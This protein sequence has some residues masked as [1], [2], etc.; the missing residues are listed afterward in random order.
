[1]SGDAPVDRVVGAVQLARARAKYLGAMKGVAFSLLDIQWLLDQTM[2]AR[3]GAALDAEGDRLVRRYLEVEVPFRM[4]QMKEFA[5]ALEEAGAAAGEIQ[6]LEELESEQARIL[7]R[8]QNWQDEEEE[9]APRE[10]ADLA[11]RLDSAGEELDKRA[12]DFLVEFVRSSKVSREVVNTL[13]GGEEVP[14]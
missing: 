7:S 12:H 13:L 3:K 2:Q 10:L 4:Q 9:G 5:E 8:V 14:R 11:K 1:M 6:A